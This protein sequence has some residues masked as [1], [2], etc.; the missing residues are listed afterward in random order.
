ML[1]QVKK[2]FSLFNAT[3]LCSSEMLPLEAAPS[4]PK[5]EGVAI[6]SIE[7][8][9]KLRPSHCLQVKRFE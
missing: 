6:L 3:T 5:A 8:S 7:V 1:L 9:K 4:T 2:T